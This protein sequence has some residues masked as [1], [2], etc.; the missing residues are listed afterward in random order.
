[1]SINNKPCIESW[2]NGLDEPLKKTLIYAQQH[3]PYYTSRL[4][5]IQGESVGELLDCV[6]LLDKETAID[7]LQALRKN[8]INQPGRISTGTLRKNRRFMDVQYI[9]AEADAIQSFY[10]H[11]HSWTHAYHFDTLKSSTD[12]IKKNDIV[13]LRIINT[14]YDI[15]QISRNAISILWTPHANS[16]EIIQKTLLEQPIIHLL[17]IEPSA[18]IKLTIM[19][20]QSNFNFRQINVQ[21]ITLFGFISNKWRKFILKKWACFISEVFSL[22]EIR[23][24]AYL[25]QHAEIPHFHFEPLPIVTEVLHPITKERI[26]SG[27]GLLCLTPLYPFAQQ[28][29]LL[30]YLTQ[31]VIKIVPCQ[32]TSTLGFS[33]CGRERDVLFLDPEDAPHS[34]VG[35]RE[36]IECLDEYYEIVRSSDDFETLGLIEAGSV[37]WPLYKV[38]HVNVNSKSELYIHIILTYPPHLFIEKT[39][40]LCNQIK[41]ELISNNHYLR[42]KVDQDFLVVHVVPHP[43]SMQHHIEGWGHAA[44]QQIIKNR[45]C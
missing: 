18:L 14:H 9:E 5:K 12:I 37:G 45:M 43:P 35:L 28:Q 4:K 30:R 20:E 8:K 33:W 41:T 27:A 38:E 15:P 29:L 34:H 1:M 40:L 13:I 44:F 22:S 2:N 19:L 25:C 17:E 16:F 3:I 31:D 23:S 32:R 26:D 11:N 10:Q 21:C 6:P 39:D 7:H 36:V 24:K 42:Q